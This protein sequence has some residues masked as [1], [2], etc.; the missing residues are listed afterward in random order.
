MARKLSQAAG[1]ADDQLIVSR[2]DYEGLLER[3]TSLRAAVA[4]LDRVEPAGDDVMDLRQ[5]LDWL[6]SFAREV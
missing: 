3:V 2:T 4:D 1:L 5:S 6:L